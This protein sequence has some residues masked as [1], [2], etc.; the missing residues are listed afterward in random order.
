MGCADRVAHRNAD[1]ASDARRPTGPG[2]L[3]GS[4][5]QQ[6]KCSFEPFGAGKALV[7]QQPVIAQVDS[8]GAKDIQ[9]RQ[10]S[11]TPEMLKQ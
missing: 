8:Q 1:G 9:P 10:R 11:K 3:P 6:G 4:T 7:G 2:L 5:A